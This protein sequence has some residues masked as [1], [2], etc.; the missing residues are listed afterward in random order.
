[1]SVDLWF[2]VVGFHYPTPF[3]WDLY[4]TVLLDKQKNVNWRSF[5]DDWM[6]SYF[7]SFHL[8]EFVAKLVGGMDHG[9][10]FKLT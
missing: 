3:L 4:E 10:R 7:F 6:N 5:L 9:L 2:M 8:Q 1:M